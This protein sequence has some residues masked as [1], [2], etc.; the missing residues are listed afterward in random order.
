MMRPSTQKLS[1]KKRVHM[2]FRAREKPV[3]MLRLRRLWT[4][5][6]PKS[7]NPHPRRILQQPKSLPQK[8]ALQKRWWTRRRRR[9]KSSSELILLR[10]TGKAWASTVTKLGTGHK[11]NASF[12]QNFLENNQRKSAIP[13]SLI[14]GR[15]RQSA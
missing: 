4:S 3:Q 12:E 8:R 14:K 7:K 6:R 1:S 10:S 11:Q 15:F 2:T 9:N 13:K 5:T